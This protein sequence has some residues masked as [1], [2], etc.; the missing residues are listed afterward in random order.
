MLHQRSWKYL[1]FGWF[2]FTITSRSL[3]TL[4]IWRPC[5]RTTYSKNIFSFFF[6]GDQILNIENVPQA[7]NCCL[8][9]YRKIPWVCSLDQRRLDTGM[10][11]PE[12]FL[13][14]WNQMS[15]KKM[16]II[17]IVHLEKISN[18]CLMHKGV[19]QKLSLPYPLEN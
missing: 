14:V 15:Y 1:N 2:L 8:A 13:Q 6:H 19:S 10:D 3:V 18:H 12:G 9:S 7:L 17:P 4:D 16:V 11:T 5:R